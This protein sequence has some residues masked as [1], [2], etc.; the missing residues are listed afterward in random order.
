MTHD[1]VDDAIA[2]FGLE[3]ADIQAVP[4]SFSSIVRLIELAAGEQLVLKIP[5][6]KRKLFRE[7]S[8]LHAF[9]DNLPVPDV[10]DV[11]VPDD[12]RPGA[13]LLSRLPGANIVGPVA[14]GL[15][16]QMGGLL[17]KLH[18]A[19]GGVAWCVRRTNTSDPFFHENMAVI[20]Q[21]TARGER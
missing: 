1:A 7:L 15:A 21:L 12:H 17:G 3:I 16:R 6:V 13:L 18:N 8:A 9:H 2:H 5:Y 20:R 4:D 19:L 14:V 10:I 11:W